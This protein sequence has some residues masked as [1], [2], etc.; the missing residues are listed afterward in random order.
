M[1]Y[2]WNSRII[3]V[4]FKILNWICHLQYLVPPTQFLQEKAVASLHTVRARNT[5]I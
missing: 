4:A 2:E 5:I 3:D 1:D